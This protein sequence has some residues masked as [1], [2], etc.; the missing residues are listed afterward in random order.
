MDNGKVIK[1]YIAGDSTVQTYDKSHI[2]QAG[3]GQF[4][5]SYFKTNINFINHSMAGR[6]SKSFVKEGRLNSILDAIEEKDYLLIQMGHNDAAKDKPERYTKPYDEYKEYLKMYIDG[7][8]KKGAIPIL[9]TP[10][11]TLNFDGK[12]FVNDFHE[13]CNSMKELAMEKKVKCIDL[14]ENSLEYF[15]SIGYD[16]TYTLFMVSSNGT[17]YAHFN[18]K[19]AKRIADIVSKELVKVD[20]IFLNYIK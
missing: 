5:D 13:Y 3:W 7:A 12:Q 8:R 4:I 20:N 6:S 18:Q 2:P 19:G 9:I 16:E 15:T 17:D 1:V 10:V 14:M 11:A